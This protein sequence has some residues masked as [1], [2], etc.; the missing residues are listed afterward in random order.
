MSRFVKS[1]FLLCG[2]ILILAALPVFGQENSNGLE[3]NKKP[4]K[5][6]GESVKGKKIDWTKPFLV[7]MESSL[8]KEGKFEKEKTKLIKSEGDAELVEVV[9]QAFAAVGDSGWL[10]YLGAQ[11]IKQL[12]ISAAQ[13]SENFSVSIVSE[14]PTVALANSVSSRLKAIINTSLMVHK[15]GIKKLGDDEI[16]LLEATRADA[17]EKTVNLNISL[18]ASDFQEIV[19]R[20]INESKENT[21]A[22]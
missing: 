17:Q 20:R 3:V 9:K 4:L 2:L 18:S 11:G 22:K 21:S 12:K 10:G 14:Q 19:K 6:L 5:D 8:T 15:N 7:E 1:I 16:K 13:N